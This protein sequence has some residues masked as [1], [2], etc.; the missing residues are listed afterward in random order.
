MKL[1]IEHLIILLAEDV[2]GSW[3]FPGCMGSQ[4]NNQMFIFLVILL[5][6]F[7]V[8]SLRELKKGE[9]SHVRV[10]MS[11]RKSLG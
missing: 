11:G 4:I 2:C 7:C 9:R 3:R 8:I 6:H 5:P 10:R 1:L